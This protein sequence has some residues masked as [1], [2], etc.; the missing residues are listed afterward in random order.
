MKNQETE[1]EKWRRLQLD[2]QFRPWAQDHISLRDL[3]FRDEAQAYA[4]GLD[5][6]V[7]K[8]SA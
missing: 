1:L 6:Y 4:L 5:R 7:G 2:M 3:E 8:K